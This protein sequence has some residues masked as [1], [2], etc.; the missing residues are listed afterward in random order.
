[1]IESGSKI[2]TE[3]VKGRARGIERRILRESESGGESNVVGWKRLEGS[4][5]LAWVLGRESIPLRVPPSSGG[6]RSR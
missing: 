1:M 6:S 4:G 5:S 2:R 3:T